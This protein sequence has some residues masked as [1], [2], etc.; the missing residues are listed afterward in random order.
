[1]SESDRPIIDTWVHKKEYFYEFVIG[2]FN[3]LY[4]ILHS[5]T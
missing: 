1:M 5:N 4:K 2:T 3:Y